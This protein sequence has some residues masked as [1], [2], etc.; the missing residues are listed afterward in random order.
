MYD[1][2]RGFKIPSKRDRKPADSAHPS[3][4]LLG[5]SWTRARHAVNYERKYVVVEL[6]CRDGG[7]VKAKIAAENAGDF[8]G[9]S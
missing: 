3:P 6:A 2:F 5:Q 8:A 7:L 9:H 1:T 4:W